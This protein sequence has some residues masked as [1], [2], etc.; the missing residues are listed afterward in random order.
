MQ[1]QQQQQGLAAQLTVGN[2]EPS[3]PAV[4]NLEPS[5]P[6]VGNLEPS[7]PAVGNLEPS[8]PAVPER[9]S[10]DDLSDDD[11]WN[12]RAETAEEGAQKRQRHA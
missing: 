6:A 10:S 5:R 11:A 1:E 8:R 4:G 7:R 12:G 9:Y 3:R 2:L